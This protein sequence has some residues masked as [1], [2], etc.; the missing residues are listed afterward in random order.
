[1][2][3]FV[4]FKSVAE[5]SAT[6]SDKAINK[7]NKDFPIMRWGESELKRFA[8]VSSLLEAQNL[9]SFGDY[10]A[11]EKIRAVGEFISPN[12]ENK[13]IMKTAVCG[14]LPHIPNYLRGVPANMIQIKSNAKKK[15]IIDI[16][17][18]CTIFDGID[19]KKLAE[20]CGFLANAITAVEQTGY[21]VNLNALCACKNNEN[22]V[23]FCVNIK[24]ADSPLNLLNIAYPLTNKAFCR[25]TFLHWIDTNVKSSV[26]INPASRYGYVLNSRQAKE[27]FNVQGLFFSMVDLVNENASVESIESKINEYLKENNN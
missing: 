23:G 7:G 24:E 8:G 25:A 1:M 4:Y 9:L 22:K 11:A 16:Y 17:V 21:R 5:L 20:K 3:T 26:K 13:A 6:L 15:P 18:E 27:I 19:C 2:N 12:N 14:C 10:K